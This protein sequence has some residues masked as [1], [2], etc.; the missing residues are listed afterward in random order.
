MGSTRLPGKVLADL[1]GQPVLAH[2][3]ERATAIPGVDGVV[4]ATSDLDRDDVIVDMARAQGWAWARGS[5]SDVLDRYYRVATEHGADHVVRVTA[6][7]PLLDYS[8]AGEVVHRHSLD[9]NDYT[10]NLTV[11]GSGMPLGT[12]V[13]ILTFRALERSWR[14][15]DQPHHRE[16]VDEYI[17]DHPELFRIGLVEAPSPL[18]RPSYRLTLDTEEDLALLRE[19]FSSLHVDGQLLDVAHVVR[20]LD[21][22][23]GARTG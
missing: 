22:R 9:G 19:I 6:D 2:V 12:G 14:E 11:W 1:C 13:E 16:H 4:V 5:E 20:W 21:R 7:C 10:H 3:V 15:G 18:R 23:A 8:Q 17:G